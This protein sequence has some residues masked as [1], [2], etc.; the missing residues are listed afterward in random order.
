MIM[1]LRYVE[2]VVGEF[3]K[4]RLSRFLLMVLSFFWFVFFFFFN[5]FLVISTVFALYLLLRS[6]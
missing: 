2:I 3:P 4:L 6:F 1:M 5:T